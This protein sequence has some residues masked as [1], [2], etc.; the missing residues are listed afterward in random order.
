[1]LFRSFQVGGRGGARLTEAERRLNAE[2]SRFWI[3]EAIRLTSVTLES[4]QI[5]RLVQSALQPQRGIPLILDG[6]EPANLHDQRPEPGGGSRSEHFSFGTIV[7]SIEAPE[8]HGRLNSALLTALRSE[9]LER[10]AI[11][12]GRSRSVEYSALGRLQ[13][14]Q[15]Q[16][17]EA[18]LQ[19]RLGLQERY[20]DLQIQI[21]RAH[22]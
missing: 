19:T 18:E 15:R 1:M 8:A 7:A 20:R 16:Q 11:L 17:I 10:E 3:E 12:Q 9:L 4:A 21:G 5:D 14:A 2:L 13:S 22:V 6:T